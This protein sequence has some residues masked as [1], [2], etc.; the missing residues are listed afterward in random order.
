MNVKRQKTQQNQRKSKE[1]L[2]LVLVLLVA[3]YFRIK[4]INFGLPYSL[5]PNESTYLIKILYLLKHWFNPDFVEVSN[6]YLYLNSFFLIVANKLL[7]VSSLV[8]ALEVDP[9]ILYLP[10]RFLSL[11]FGIFTIIVVFLIGNLF[12][13]FV[14]IVASILVALSFLHLKYSQLFLPH[15]HM[16]FFALLSCFFCIKAFYTINTNL[17]LTRKLLILSTVLAAL[18]TSMHYI[19]FVSFA[20]VL[21]VIFLSKKSFDKNFIKFCTTLFLLIF[22]VLNP[23]L[24]FSLISLLVY[25]FT[26]YVKSYSIYNAGSYL[27]HLFNFLVYGIGP[28]AWVSAFGILKYKN[29]YDLNILKILFCMPVLYFA[30]L[31]LFHLTSAAYSVLLLPFFSIASA[32]VL[33]LFYESYFKKDASLMKLVCIIIFLFAF[34]LPLKYSKKYCQLTS[35]EDTRVLATEWIKRNT[36]SDFKISWDRNSIQLNW[37]NTYNSRDLRNLGIY[38]ELLKNDQRFLISSVFLKDKK[39]FRNLRKKVDYVV[40]NSLDY[41]R[42]LRE[43]NPKLLEKYY[44]RLLKLKPVITFNPYLRDKETKIRS[45]LIEE[46]YSPSSQLFDRERTGPLIKIYKL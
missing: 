34:Y 1:L 44:K 45:S 43:K 22:I 21:L 42:V 37:F 39:W 30:F 28:V 31:G 24:I 23:Y 3:F 20:P 19:G 27:P 38:P 16:T 41:E 7:G 33:N 36:T 5:N 14:G 32:L 40:I 6:L 8:G 2:L 15:S 13:S 10:L 11:I 4:S 18:S 25:L 12:N 35:L 46:L 29:C 17:E 26:T 9:K